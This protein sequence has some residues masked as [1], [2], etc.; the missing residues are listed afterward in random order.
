MRREVIGVLILII[1][2][3]PLVS[4]FSFNDFWK[5]ITGQAA[6][7]EKDELCLAVCPIPGVYDDFDECCVAFEPCKQYNEKDSDEFLAD[8]IQ[9]ISQEKFWVNE[10][11]V[12]DEFQ[13]EKTSPGDLI[14]HYS[15]SG[16]AK[17]SQGNYDA[18][19]S[20]AKLTTGIEGSSNTAYYFDGN[21]FIKSNLNELS[22]QYPSSISVWFKTDKKVDG[23]AIHLENSY[24]SGNYGTIRFYEDGNIRFYHRI[25]WTTYGSIYMN[26]NYADGKWH[27]YVVTWDGS[28]SKVYYDGVFQKEASYS[29]SLNYNSFYIGGTWYRDYFKGSLDEIKVYDKELSASEVQEVYNENNQQVPVPPTPTPSGQEC[30][31]AGGE[32]KSPGPCPTGTISIGQKDCGPNGV[33]CVEEEPE[34]PETQDCYWAPDPTSTDYKKTITK[35]NELFFRWYD[36]PR[37][38]CWEGKWRATQNDWPAFLYADRNTGEIHEDRESWGI[39]V[40]KDLNMDERFGDWFIIDDPENAGRKIWSKEEFLVCSIEGEEKCEGEFLYVCVEGNWVFQGKVEDKCGYVPDS[41]IN[42]EEKCEGEIYYLCQNNN[43]VNKGR[44]DGKCGY[45]E[46]EEEISL[47]CKLKSASWITEEATEGDEVI[48][49]I[50]G[51]GCEGEEIQFKIF[52]KDLAGNDL[53]E[54]NPSKVFFSSEGIARGYWRAEYEDDF[55]GDPEYFFVAELVSDPSNKIKS[56]NML[57]VKEYEE[58]NIFLEV[59][60]SKRNYL[61]GE[62]I[63]LIRDG[64]EG[65]LFGDFISGIPEKFIVVSKYD[66]GNFVLKDI[67]LSFQKYNDLSKTRDNAEIKIYD[68]N[69]GLLHEGTFYFSTLLFYDTFEAENPGGAKDLNEKEF[70]LEVPYFENARNIV[71]SYDGD[72]TR[73]EEDLFLNIDLDLF[74]KENSFIMNQGKKSLTGNLRLNIYELSAGNWEDL[75][76]GF[77]DDSFVIQSKEL[78]YLNEVISLGNY[79][80]ESGMY[81]IDI[82]FSHKDNFVSDYSYFTIGSC[83]NGVVDP[84]EEC[85]GNDF[86]ELSNSC[87][88]YGA[89]DSGVVSCSDSCL[90]DNSQCGICGNGV[91]ENDEVCDGEEILCSTYY[92]DS[93][94]RG[95]VKC[96]G[97]CS[98]WDFQD[99]SYKS[100]KICTPNECDLRYGSVGAIVAYRCANDGSSWKPDCTCCTSGKCD[101]SCA[102]NTF[103]AYCKC[104]G[105]SV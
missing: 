97:D 50:S 56:S 77:N 59:A 49:K 98:W 64:E 26:K 9:C 53:L 32:C 40:P 2:V 72:E 8:C 89:F 10:E 80:L 90:I 73:G 33:C 54:Q 3:V 29:G 102:S 81:K 67:G 92:K 91:K 103:F 14:S 60:T 37:L 19:V 17:D 28:T 85:D 63:E 25:G 23:K 100:Q 82:S 43:W 15:F 66:H 35:H 62:E 88:D 79:N 58:F 86:G 21:D 4:A 31:A 39:I 13:R 84:G 87:L 22:M 16:N 71:L 48:L 75:D 76:K 30:I 96:K 34:I 6:T 94:W 5:K 36:E 68:F 99:C 12:E 69:G 24:S 104:P 74:F 78:I 46:E 57:S 42:G 95:V 83:G 27:N 44:I 41:C 61:K 7:E 20:G 47:D 101:T 51:T 93:N 1:L 65:N 55:F 45:G 105:Y 18:S 52:E 11:C 70:Y 38:L